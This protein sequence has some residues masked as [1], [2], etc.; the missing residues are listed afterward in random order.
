MRESSNPI[1]GLLIVGCF[2]VLCFV[3][4]SDGGT[5]EVGVLVAHTAT[6]LRHN[7]SAS[8]DHF[9]ASSPSIG[10]HLIDVSHRLEIQLFII[11]VHSAMQGSRFPLISTF[12]GVKVTAKTDCRQPTT[13]VQFAKHD[14]RMIFYF[15]DFIFS[16]MQLYVFEAACFYPAFSDYI[17]NRSLFLHSSTVS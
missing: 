17:S 13:F 5:S 11:Y 16:P 15:Y 2:G 7:Y 8:L 6:A 1:G 9:K 4:R 10:H 3:C 12:K 14:L